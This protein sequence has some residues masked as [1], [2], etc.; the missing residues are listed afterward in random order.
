MYHKAGT[1]GLNS[2]CVSC[3]SDATKLEVSNDGNFVILEVDGSNG[4]VV[5]LMSKDMEEVIAGELRLALGGLLIDKEKMVVQVQLV[6]SM[7]LVMIGSTFHQPAS[8]TV[9]SDLKGHSTK[10]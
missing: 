1:L 4:L 3:A 2:S 6:C 9:A 10:M 7:H 5:S 8:S